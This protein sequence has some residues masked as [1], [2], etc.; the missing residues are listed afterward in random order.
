MGMEQAEFLDSLFPGLS[1]LTALYRELDRETAR[2]KRAAG[3]ECLEACRKCCTPERAQIE[4]AVLDC[5]PLSLHLWKLGEAESCLERLAANGRGRVCVIYD[6]DPFSASGCKQYPWRPLLCRLFGFSAVLDK[7][8]RPR[9]ALCRAIRNADPRAEA[10][11][12]RVLAEGLNPVV[13]PHWARRVSSL[14]PHLGQR[15]Y[16]INQA[17]KLALEKVGFLIHLLQGAE[18]AK[19][20]FRAKRV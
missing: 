7:H 15:R 4:A 13:I 1:E 14:N 12:N 16:P 3:L 18:G 9:V 5:L 10:R 17:L 8:G 20:G 11:A 2:F 19:P 6:A